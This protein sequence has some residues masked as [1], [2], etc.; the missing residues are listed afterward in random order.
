MK[1]PR[2]RFSRRIIEQTSVPALTGKR[3]KI[4]LACGHTRFTS[5][6]APGTYTTCPGCR[7][8]IEEHGECNAPEA[9]MDAMKVKR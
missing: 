3:M 1:I 8:Q 5:T 4:L 6:E 7:L 9:L 2:K